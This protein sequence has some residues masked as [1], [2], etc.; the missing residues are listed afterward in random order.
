M[1]FLR[2]AIGRLLCIFARH[3]WESGLTSLSH[4]RHRWGR[5]RRPNCHATRSEGYW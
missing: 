5:C 2:K 1:N 3:D 4:P